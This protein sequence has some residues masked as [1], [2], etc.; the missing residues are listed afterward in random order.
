MP[1]RRMERPDMVDRFKGFYSLL[2]RKLSRP[3]LKVDSWAEFSDKN[4]KGSLNYY[5]S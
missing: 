4:I 1:M 5:C 3:V 2:K